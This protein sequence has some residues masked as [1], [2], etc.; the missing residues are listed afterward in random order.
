MRAAVVKSGVLQRQADRG[1]PAEVEIDLALD[2]GA[3]RDRPG[4]RHAHRDARRFALGRDAAG[5]D[6][7]LG[8][9]IDLAVR[10]VERGHDQRPAQQAR[11][12]AD[13]RDGD[14]DRAA[15]TGEG[16]QLGGDQDRRDVARP[17]LL[18]GDVDAQPLE[19][20]GHD[21]FG[22]RRVAQ[23]VTGAVEAD[24]EAVADQLVRANAVELDE[25]LEPD[26]R[27]GTDARTRP[28]TRAVEIASAAARASGR[29][30]A[31]TSRARDP[32]AGR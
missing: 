24:H 8:D 17:E 21:L 18:A 2:G 7:A 10:R 9:G 27:G 16:R 25:I 13:R 19:D 29:I 12:I 31:G 20:V 11:R 4:G 32:T 6:G 15:G 23:P 3:G 22:E 14:V 5:D 1:Q 30:T 28:G 26:R